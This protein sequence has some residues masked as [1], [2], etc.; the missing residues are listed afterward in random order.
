[1]TTFFTSDLHFFHKH[2]CEYTDRPKMSVDEHTEWL[3]EIWNKQVTPKDVVYSLGDFAF[4][5]KRDKIQSL[6]NRLNGQK[7][8]IKGNHC[9]RKA[10]SGVTGINWFKDYKE[11]NIE[12]EGTKYHICMM[13][14]PIYAWHK[15]G[16][17]SLMCHGHS[18][19]A[20]QMQGKA[21]DVGIDN[22]YNLFGEHRFFS[23]EDIVE[24]MKDRPIV[25][26]DYG[27][28]N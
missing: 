27:R 8:F 12:H 3:V 10:W 13:H 9:D 18:H 20:L 5:S 26:L 16:H 1:M 28:A 4:H 19:G 11:I 15:Q 7:H 6:V 14:F 23:F 2:I 24:F 17:G 25:E 21:L 22:A